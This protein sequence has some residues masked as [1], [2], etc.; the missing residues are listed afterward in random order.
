MLNK[1]LC[2]CVIGTNADID[3]C[4]ENLH[5][6]HSDGYCINKQAS[7]DC[8]CHVGYTGDGISCT[9]R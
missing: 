8:Q 3:E 1:V 6:C 7:F 2:V 5:N 4:D 9:G